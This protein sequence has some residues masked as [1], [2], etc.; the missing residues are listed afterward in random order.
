M[1]RTLVVTL[2][3]LLSGSFWMLFGGA[4]AE[5]A[6]KPT[7]VA[8]ASAVP[9]LADPSLQATTQFDSIVLGA[10]CFWGAEKRYAAI[11][12]VL[13]AV[14]G[15]AGGKGVTPEYRVITQARYRMD[16]N[17]HA[18][19]VRVRFDASK[20]ALR[21][22]LMRYFESHDPTQGN[23]QGNDVGTQ[24]RSIILTQNPS[25]AAVAE[26]VLQQYQTALSKAGLGKITTQIQPLTQFYEAEDY[27]Q[28]YLVKN[29]NGYCPDHSTGVKFAPTT[30]ASVDNRALLRGKH[31]LV[32]E[33]DGYCPYCEKF[34]RDVSE[35]YQGKIPLHYRNAAQLGALSLKT[36]TWATP[37]LY[38]LDNGV[39]VLAHQGYVN[40]KQFDQALAA[41]DTGDAKAFAL[42]VKQG[43]A[44]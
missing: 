4:H 10:G 16:P 42:A 37:T 27:H 11:P 34:R 32:L 24:Y 21:E 18:E 29:P 6:V 5:T 1:N 23:R 40:A 25:Q 14:S 9:T 36:P 2:A 3:L 15:Y 39:E 17:N 41:F 28:D 20:V 8:S 7:A 35:K 19:V 12:G 30:L 13:D 33:A 31:I 38:F 26:Q 44:R 22:L 43:G